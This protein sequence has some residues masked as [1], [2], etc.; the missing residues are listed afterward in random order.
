ML[1]T[2]HIFLGCFLAGLTQ[3]AAEIAWSRWYM[4]RLEDRLR[5]SFEETQKAQALSSLTKQ[6][7]EHRGA[8]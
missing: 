3:R 2:F 6:W 8:N 7:R 5:K 4:S 1:V